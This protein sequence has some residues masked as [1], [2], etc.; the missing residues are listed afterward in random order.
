MAND[1]SPEV[2]PA[3]AHVASAVSA[4]RALE[5]EPTEAGIEAAVAIATEV[6]QAL[7]AASVPD[8]NGVA[9]IQIVR[10]RIEALRGE[11]LA[12]F[13]SEV[14]VL[15]ARNISN[16]SLGEHLLVEAL[17]CAA[18]NHRSANRLNLA[19]LRTTEALAVAQIRLGAND[20]V[21]RLCWSELG[22]TCEAAGDVTAARAAYRQAH[23]ANPGGLST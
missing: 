18:R 1:R 19:R 13:S 11:P 14:A 7:A 23:H 12:S 16:G 21:T 22:E 9:A 2:E 5:Q 6:G 15:L 8:V 10:A 17:L 3:K 4:L 20:P